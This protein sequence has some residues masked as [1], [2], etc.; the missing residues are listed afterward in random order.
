MFA[1]ALVDESAAAVVVVVDPQA[2]SP[3]P[4]DAFC[5]DVDVVAPAVVV[6][7]KMK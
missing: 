2:V 6:D 3:L 5:P 7:P 1:A 4:P